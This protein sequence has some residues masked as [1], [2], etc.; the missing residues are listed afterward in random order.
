MHRPIYSRYRAQKCRG[1]QREATDTFI[2]EMRFNT[3]CHSI[4]L[5]LALLKLHISQPFGK[6]DV[7]SGLMRK[8]VPIALKRAHCPARSRQLKAIFFQFFFLSSIFFS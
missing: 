3:L 8:A 6:Q 5:C 2:G 1:Q 7:V 4:C